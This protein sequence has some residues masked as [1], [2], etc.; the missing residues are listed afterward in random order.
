M[1]RR[2]LSLALSVAVFLAPLAAKAQSDTGEITIT[3]V[4][5]TTGQPLDDARVFLTGAML[6]SALTQRSGTVKYTDVPTGIYRVRVLR[7]GYNGARTNEFE[8]LGGKDVTVKFALDRTQQNQGPA[9]NEHLKVIGTVV[10]RQNVQINTNDISDESPIRR[11]SDSMLDALDKLAG[12]SVNQD[13]NDPDSAV[14]ISLNGHDESQTAIS[15]D[16]IPLSTPGSAMNLRGINTDLFSGSSVSFSPTAAGLGGGVNFRTLEPTQSWNERLSSTYGTYDRWNYQMSVTGSVGPLGIA[17]MH[18]DRGGNNPLTFQDYEDSSGLTYPH[19]GFSDN[20]G[21]LVKLRYRIADV[22]TLTGTYMASNGS[23]SQLC[24]QWVTALPCGIGP[25]NGSFNRFRM[26][27]L[28]G[29]SLIG[30]VAFTATAFGIASRNTQ[31][32]L[33][34]IVAGVP[35]PLY[36]ESQ[37]HTNGYAFTASAGHDKHTFTLTGS[38]FSSVNDFYPIVSV[39]PYVI[40]SGIGINAHQ[41]QF[42]DVIKST[43][44]LNLNF[45]SSLADTSGV[46]YSVLGGGGA[47]WRP[48]G[49]DTLQMALALGSAQPPP[50]IPRTFSNPVTARFNCDAG[51]AIVSGPGDTSSQ[52]QSSTSYNLDWTHLWRTGQITVNAFSQS[53]IGQ[54]INALVNSVGEPA[55][56]FPP[57]YIGA[58]GATWSQPE[59]CGAIPFNPAGVYVT[60]PIAG[61]ARDYRGVDVSGRIALGPNVVVLPTY[62]LNDA[63]LVAADSRLTTAESTSIV[64]AQLPGRPIHRA[65]VTFDAEL[66]GNGFE[67]LANAQYTGGNNNRYLVPYT[68]VSW[69]ISHAFGPGRLTLFE[70]NAFNTM[71]GEFSTLE[72]AEPVP[73]SGGGVVF[74]AANPL[75]PR[76][77]SLNYTVQVGKGAPKL[78][79]NLAQQ[80]RMA[81]GGGGGE[82]AP[83]VTGRAGGA[84]GPPGGPGG[85]PG[86]PG[87]FHRNVLPAGGDPFSLATD[88]PLCNAEAQDIARPLLEGLRAYVTAY[89]RHQPLP[90]TGEFTIVAHTTAAGS[91][92]PYWLEIRPQGPPGGPQR[93]FP[94]REA[95]SQGATVSGAPEITPSP[96]A[97]PS[98]TPAPQPSGQRPRGEGPQRF[99]A[100][101]A[102]EYIATLTPDEAK[103]KGIDTQGRVFMGYAPGIGIFGVMPRQ[104]PQGGGS[105]RGQ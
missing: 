50:T 70:T 34:E 69:G 2:T 75:L 32:D 30:N 61:T 27:Y 16:G 35:N 19:G 15:L 84:F 36:T 77:I 39:T 80:A 28:T 24:T 72:Y 92:V 79:S 18:T 6:V 43:D 7:R 60:E 1:L 82:R 10:V 53:Q 58:I 68:T 20:L 41:L 25:D 55:S 94:Q 17:V 29:S 37:S 66:P 38:L 44:K 93:R 87:Q 47:T 89:E 9:N 95:A 81:G 42:A 40:N 65:G 102:C 100:I 48:T 59:I 23:I 21:D 54:T 83:N 90:P 3:V 31:D 91:A 63:V 64:G 12:V 101:F 14:T 105:L 13:S 57:G 97:S 45:N 22:A 104:L 71:A 4:D 88:N 33:D 99:R 98:T 49:N 74:F 52:Q 26:E 73:V 11:I 62:A 67:L 51:T 85:S 96:A 76:T 103:A 5:T 8:V 56:Y 46:G 86:G 78:R